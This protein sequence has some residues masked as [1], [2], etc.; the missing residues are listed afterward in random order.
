MQELNSESLKFK[1][2]VSLG[3]GSGYGYDLVGILENGQ[4]VS[5]ILGNDTVWVNKLNIDD[6]RE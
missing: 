5:I 3:S 6:C 1:Q 2:I 4:L